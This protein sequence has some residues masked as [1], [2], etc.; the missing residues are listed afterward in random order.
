MFYWLSLSQVKTKNKF[1]ML[2]TV[3]MILFQFI[4]ALDSKESE[5]NATFLFTSYKYIIVFIHCCIVSTFV[6]WRNII[7]FLDEF[8][9]SSWRFFR[10]NGYFMFYRYNNKKIQATIK[11]Q[12]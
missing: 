6:E 2:F 8:T 10:L 1:T 12:K 7:N 4:M 5:G 3:I 11:K 9:S